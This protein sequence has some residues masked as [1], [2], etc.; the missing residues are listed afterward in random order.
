MVNRDYLVSLWY[1]GSEITLHDLHAPDPERD[2]SA[3]QPELTARQA[4]LAK[5]LYETTKYI[6]HHNPRLPPVTL[7]PS[8]VQ[9]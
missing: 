9:Q 8:D 4:F 1:D 7:T 3:T 2:V 5:G 6:M